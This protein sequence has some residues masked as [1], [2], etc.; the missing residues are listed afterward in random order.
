MTRRRLVTPWSVTGNPESRSRA[1]I[2]DYHRAQ[3]LL[4]A[5]AAQG[6]T[7]DVKTKLVFSL[8]LLPLLAFGNPYVG[9]WAGVNTVRGKVISNPYR[10]PFLAT[11]YSNGTCSFRSYDY[12]GNLLGT[13]SGGFS[14]ST[15]YFNFWNGTYHYWGTASTNGTLSGSYINT[16]T[17]VWGNINAYREFLNQP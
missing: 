10:Q 4:T 5:A 1:A 13:G 2:F 9:R 3:S 16:A 15:G 17:G 12:A 14:I 6:T 8:L 11:V 7:D